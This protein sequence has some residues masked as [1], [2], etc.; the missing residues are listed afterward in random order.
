MRK[1][2]RKKDGS[3]LKNSSKF[4]INVKNTEE[5]TLERRKLEKNSGLVPARVVNGVIEQK[6]KLNLRSVATIVSC[7]LVLSYTTITANAQATSVK[8]TLDSI[9][10]TDGNIT[11]FQYDSVGHCTHIKSGGYNTFFTYDLNGNL[12]EEVQSYINSIK[13]EY[14]YD[15]NGNC[16]LLIKYLWCNLEWINTTKLEY[17]FDANGKKDYTI[18]SEYLTD[19]QWHLHNKYVYEYDINGNNTKVIYYWYSVGW[20]LEKQ[21]EYRYDG[22]GNVVYFSKQY[23]S[24]YGISYFDKSYYTYINNTLTNVITKR[25]DIP[26][27]YEEYIYDENINKIEYILYDVNISNEI[28]DNN[29]ILISYDSTLTPQKKIEYIY[30]I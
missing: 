2:S 3:K 17:F 26:Y 29:F 12:V 27:K 6:K 22:N 16:I 23:N 24:N 4:S 7:L 30:D 8:Q 11:R 21:D 15:N 19:N 13:T 1:S 18:Q 5:M 20:Q 14:T 28:Y 10:S 25:N 9:I